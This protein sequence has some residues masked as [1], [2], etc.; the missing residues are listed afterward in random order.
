[1]LIV[2]HLLFSVLQVHIRWWGVER[3]GQYV[4]KYPSSKDIW[5]FRFAGFREEKRALMDH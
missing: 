5:Y 4:A 2:L 3:K 1:M